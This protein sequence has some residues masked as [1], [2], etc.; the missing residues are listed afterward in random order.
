ML[1]AAVSL[2]PMVATA[3]ATSVGRMAGIADQKPAEG[4]SVEVDGKF[5]VPYVA[6][7]PGTDITFEM[8]PIP[9]GTYKMGSPESEADRKDDEGPQVDVIVNPM[10][11]AKTEVTWQQYK[12]YMKLYSIFKDF[13]ANGS[14]K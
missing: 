9:G 14:G 6:T 5:M 1:A 7:I 12:E 13:E 11:V 10:W 8:I 2:C 3:D 4:P